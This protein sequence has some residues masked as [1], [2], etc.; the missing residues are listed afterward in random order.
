MTYNPQIFISFEDLR[1]D[2]AAGMTQAQLA[3]KHGCHVN[4]IAQLMRD[5]GIVG[6]RGGNRNM[7]RPKPNPIRLS[8]AQYSTHHKRVEARRGRPK[9]CEACGCTDPS[10][11]YDWANLTGRYDDPSDY[12]R[13]CRSCHWKHDHAQQSPYLSDS[14]QER[15]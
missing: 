8:T 11:T 10:K 6:R 4:T 13:M 7:N 2:Y 5:A 12:K 9:M 1:R 3:T 15:L 14:Y